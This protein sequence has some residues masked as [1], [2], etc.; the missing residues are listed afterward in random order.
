[1]ILLFNGKIIPLIR[2]VRQFENYLRSESSLIF[3]FTLILEEMEQVSGGKTA[4]GS[5][6]VKHQFE[7]CCEHCKKKIWADEEP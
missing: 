5:S 2:A 6:G 1:L 7:Y 4:A 3:P